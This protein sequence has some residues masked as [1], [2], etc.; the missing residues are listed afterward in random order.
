MDNMDDIENT[1]DIKEK[2][3]IYNLIKKDN[4][5]IFSLKLNNYLNHYN[6]IYY[7]LK[8]IE[9]IF[10]YKKK[11]HKHYYH[12]VA[13]FFES[14]GIIDNNIILGENNEFKSWLC[15]I[16]THAEIAALK[17]IL[18]K[19]NF[20]KNN[21]LP[22]YNLIVLKISHTGH[23]GNSQPCFHCMQTLYKSNIPI[24]YI[25]YSTNCASINKVKFSD[26]INKSSYVSSGYKK[27]NI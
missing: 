23:I 22:K 21:I 18:K 4:N 2:R 5:K 13:V 6:E 15:P 11:Y 14:K 27:N 26:L 17:K 9:E 24:K 3:H 1:D 8:K 7:I 20:K 19:Y 10:N 25:Y 16:S 12:H